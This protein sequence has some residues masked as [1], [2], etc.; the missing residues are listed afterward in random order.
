MTKKF[1]QIEPEKIE[2]DSFYFI[3]NTIEKDK[4]NEDKYAE[5]IY[6]PIII[7]SNSDK[8]ILIEGFERVTALKHRAIKEIDA[9]ILPGSFSIEN[10]IYSILYRKTF[11]Q[12]NLIEKSV[13]V[14]KIINQFKI[15]GKKV[16]ERYLPIIDEKP[17]RKIL[18]TLLL[19]NNLAQSTKQLI[20]RENLSLKIAREFLKYSIEEQE[21][22][23]FWID[24]L[25]LG[26]N[27]IKLV[28][29]SL[30]H[31][32]KR[33]SKDISELLESNYFSELKDKEGISINTLQDRFFGELLNMRF[34]QYQSQLSQVQ[35][36]IKRFKLPPRWK[37]N[38]PKNLEGEGIE[39]NFYVRDVEEYQKVIEKLKSIDKSDDIGKLFDLL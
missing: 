15:E 29:E 7:E 26:V 14:E 1:V 25:N 11:Q 20:I 9:F 32:S 8:Y 16:V 37:I 17:S 28:L 3:S 23:F 22:L 35:E 34:P 18:E 13:I 38:P 24:F 12:L 31:L 5:N 2:E 27:K 6:P 39:M 19:L 30:N 33:D 36:I 21:T 10:F 4:Q